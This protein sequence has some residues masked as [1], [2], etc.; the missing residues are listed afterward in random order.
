MKYSDR[1]R[2]NHTWGSGQPSTPVYTQITHRIYAATN[3]LG[4]SAKTP[5]VPG[6]GKS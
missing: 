5:F 2:N 1:S 6:H 4:G 3:G